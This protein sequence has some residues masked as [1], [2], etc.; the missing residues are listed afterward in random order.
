MLVAQK[1]PFF[2][3]M[4][5]SHGNSSRKNGDESSK[6]AAKIAAT[7][8]PLGMCPAV[9]QA[10]GLEASPTI[11]SQT[12]VV[13]ALGLAAVSHHFA[14]DDVGGGRFAGRAVRGGPRFLRD[15]L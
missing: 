13:A 8:V 7:P 11:D 3:K 12:T 14:G 4:G 6:E 2:V 15:V 5:A 10:A 9:S 1:S